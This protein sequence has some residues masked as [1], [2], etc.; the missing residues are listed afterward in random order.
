MDKMNAREKKGKKIK[1]N[2]VLCSG[3]MVPAEAPPRN[4]E[5]MV[6]AVRK[7]GKYS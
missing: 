4:M 7:Y 6:N 2:F 5:A 3:C 1:G